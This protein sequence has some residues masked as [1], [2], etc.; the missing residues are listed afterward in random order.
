[1][2]LQLFSDAK[3]ARSILYHFEEPGHVPNEYLMPRVQVFFCSVTSS[4]VS[5]LF[6]VGFLIFC[7]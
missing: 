2:E 7:I 4:V 5:A 6:L 3:C 1:V